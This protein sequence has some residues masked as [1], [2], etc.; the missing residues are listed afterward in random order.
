MNWNGKDANEVALNAIWAEH[1]DKEK[2]YMQPKTKFT[3]NPM[4]SV[5]MNNGLGSR[6]DGAIDLVLRIRK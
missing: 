4:S 1:V 3:C 6:G 2:Q 5:E